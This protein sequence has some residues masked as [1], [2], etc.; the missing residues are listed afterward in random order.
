MAVLSYSGVGFITKF[1]QTLKTYL[2]DRVW[3]FYFYVSKS[4][5]E[6]PVLLHFPGMTKT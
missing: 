2:N 1:H 6:E 4:W 5:P 3:D